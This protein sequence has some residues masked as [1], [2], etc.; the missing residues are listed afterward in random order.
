M[1]RWHS[2]I[3]SGY[4]CYPNTEEYTFSIAH[5]TFSRIDHI[6][7]HKSKF[8]EFNKIEIISSISSNHNAMRVNINYK[9]KIVKKNK[10]KNIRILRNTFLNIQQVT[11]EIKRGIKYLWKQMTMQHDNSKPMGCSI[12]SSKREVSSNTTLPQET[13]K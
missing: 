6:L 12:S 3:S 4:I 11:E 10:N 5:G 7:G 8:S 2:L 9:K 1:M 13:R